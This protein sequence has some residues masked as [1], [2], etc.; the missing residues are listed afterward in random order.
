[1]ISAA[2]QLT[3]CLF[4]SA[5][6]VLIGGCSE[7]EIVSTATIGDRQFII[8]TVCSEMVRAQGLSK[9]TSLPEGKGMLFIFNSIDYHGIWMRDMSFPIDIMWIN[10]L[11]SIVHIEEKVLPD[12]YPKIFKP[13]TPALYVLEVPAGTSAGISLGTMVDLKNISPA[14]VPCR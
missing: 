1:M 13:P 14:Q 8:E 5:V 3:R 6:V 7:R 9:R 12:T 11:R 10:E 2:H 4:L